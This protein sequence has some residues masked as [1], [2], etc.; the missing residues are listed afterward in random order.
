MDRREKLEEQQLYYKNQAKKNKRIADNSLDKDNQRIFQYRADENARKADEIGEKLTKS[1]AKSDSSGIIRVNIGKHSISKNINSIDSPI[2]QRN[3]GKG[4]PN[5]ILTFG[6]ELNNRQ[7]KLLAQLPE[8]DSKFIVTKK[9]VNMADLSALTAVT[10][11][12]FAMFTKGN[13]RLI[14]R[15]NKTSVNVDL[16]MAQQ[17]S[18]NGYKWSGH[19][20]P[21][22][23]INTL[24]PS[25]GDKA[26][27][28]CFSQ[29]Y[30]VI[31][32]SKGN[33]RIFEKE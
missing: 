12:E 3:T 28:K 33:F 4:N 20:H 26:V 14:I 21:G 18:D 15:G 13:K 17:L 5:A 11:H 8:F 10:G 30:G 6:V 27:L 2:E 32:D 7:K 1:I 9:S 23:N 25:S 29:E 16:I 19:T 22:V 31:Y 24:V